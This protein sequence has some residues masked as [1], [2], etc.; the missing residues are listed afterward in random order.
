MSSISRSRAT[1]LNS[2]PLARWTLVIGPLQAGTAF[3]LC[4]FARRGGRPG[5][6]ARYALQSQEGNAFRRQQLNVCSPWCRNSASPLFDPLMSQTGPAGNWPLLD[7]LEEFREHLGGDLTI[8]LSRRSAA[9]SRYTKSTPALMQKCILELSRRSPPPPE[10]MMRRTVVLNVVGLTR[11][12][13]DRAAMPRLSAFA[14]AGQSHRRSAPPSPPS[15][16]PR[17]RAT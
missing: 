2:A 7:G 13:L 10:A 9:A 3:R 16:A 12:L 6:G 14:R 1:R 11:S 8:T 5:T 15:P 4:H 17:N